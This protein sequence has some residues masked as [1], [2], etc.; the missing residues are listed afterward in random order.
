V[1][2]ELGGRAEFDIALVV[3]AC[4]NGR[5]A[6]ADDRHSQ[7]SCATIVSPQQQLMCQ[8]DALLMCRSSRASVRLVKQSEAKCST[9]EQLD[10]HLIFLGLLEEFLRDFG[11]EFS[12]GPS[13]HKRD[14]T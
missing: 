5:Q 10:Q 12:A 9:V 8:F 6:S 11:I 3:N 13:L 14:A 7:L 2:I 1:Q 4:P